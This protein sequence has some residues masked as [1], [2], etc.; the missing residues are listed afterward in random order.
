[1]LSRWTICLDRPR[2]PPA[3][4]PDLEVEAWSKTASEEPEDAEYCWEI[5]QGLAFHGPTLYG[6]RAAQHNIPASNQERGALDPTA[7]AFHPGSI[8]GS[9]TNNFSRKFLGSAANDFS[10]GILKTASTNSRGRCTMDSVPTTYSRGQDETSVIPGSIL[11]MA[12]GDMATPTIYDRAALEANVG[13]ALAELLLRAFPSAPP[14]TPPGSFLRTPSAN[15]SSVLDD[16]NLE[17]GDL[18]LGLPASNASLVE[19]IK[20]EEDFWHFICHVI[21]LALGHTIMAHSSGTQ[22]MYVSGETGEPSVETTGII[23]DIVRQQVVEIVSSP[24]KED[25]ELY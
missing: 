23:E 11:G 18:V 19:M 8:P 4:D 12:A 2:R 21:T 13:T 5:N 24:A 1:M 14:S 22:M 7:T 9:G 16:E 17:R 10:S 15:S 3:V 25:Y 20:A 6:S